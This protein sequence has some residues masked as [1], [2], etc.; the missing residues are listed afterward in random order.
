MNNKLMTAL[1][2]DGSQVTGIEVSRSIHEDEVILSCDGETIPINLLFCFSYY[3][4]T[5]PPYFDE[6]TQSENEELDM[7]DLPNLLTNQAY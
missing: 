1:L 6:L 4:E 5:D 2:N 7:C 3:E